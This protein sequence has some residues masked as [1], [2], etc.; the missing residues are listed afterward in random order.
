MAGGH[1]E[2]YVRLYDDTD[3]PSVPREEPHPWVE[4][5]EADFADAF[6]DPHPHLAGY[7]ASLTA[8]DEGLGRIR[9]RLAELG[10]AE[11][12]VVVYMS[13]NGFSCGHHGIWG[14]GNGTW[15][16][17]FWD[18]SVRVPFVVHVPDG[19]RGVSDE[20]VPSV[21]LHPTI[22]ELAGVVPPG[23]PWGAGESVAPLLRGEGGSGH[24]VVV[25]HAEYGGGRMVTD[26][27]WKYVHRSAG[28]DELYDLVSDPDER[29]N[30]VDDEGAAAERER[31]ASELE[32]WFAAHE[33][34]GLGAF[35]RAVSGHGQVHPLTRGLADDRTFVEPP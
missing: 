10:L 4:P 21:A 5:R 17:N 8:V 19:V 32:G 6:A 12:T 7:C 20:L 11:D 25:V 15:P 23:D 22:C 34:P 3:F 1:P 16:L 35:D 13:D 24:E 26:G 30:L 18:N 29:E 9:A 14:K 33:R 27:R 31:L 2:E 28:P